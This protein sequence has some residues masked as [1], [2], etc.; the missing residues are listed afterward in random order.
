MDDKCLKFSFKSLI[1]K[2]KMIPQ[3]TLQQ[4]ILTPSKAIWNLR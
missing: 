2:K 4:D 3:G 1:N